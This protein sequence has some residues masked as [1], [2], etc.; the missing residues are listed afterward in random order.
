[1]VQV[2]KVIEL[3]LGDEISGHERIE[4]YHGG[5]VAETLCSQCRVPGFDPWSGN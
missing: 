1:M 3:S 4:D 5:P 2:T